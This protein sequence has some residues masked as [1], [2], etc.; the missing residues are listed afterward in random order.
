M[1]VYITRT[2]FF[3]MLT[4]SWRTSTSDRSIKMS[5]SYQMNNDET[6]KF[7]AER[8]RSERK[9][10]TWVITRYITIKLFYLQPTV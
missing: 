8:K 4:G 9:A 7:E 10:K 2:C 5:L 6:K 3:L 1:A